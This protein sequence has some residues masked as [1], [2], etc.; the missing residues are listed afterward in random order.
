MKTPDACKGFG[1]PWRKTPMNV[2]KKLALNQETLRNLTPGQ[3]QEVAGG[4]ASALTCRF[5]CPPF[6][7]CPECAPQARREKE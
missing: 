6:L 2:S 3:L 5:S 4:F 7:T 1:N